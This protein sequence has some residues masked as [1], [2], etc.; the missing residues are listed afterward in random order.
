M[1]LIEN[2]LIFSLLSLGKNE[3]EN[4]FQ[5]ILE[6]KDTFLDYKDKKLKRSKNWDFSIGGFEEELEILKSHFLRKN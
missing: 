2:W 6:W 3:E 1:V 4:V 5:D